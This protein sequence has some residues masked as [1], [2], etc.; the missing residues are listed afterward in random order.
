ME[1]IICIKT[2]YWHVN[3]VDVVATYLKTCF[4][5]WAQLK[6]VP[7]FIWRSQRAASLGT[8]PVSKGDTKDQDSSYTSNRP[9]L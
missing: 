2:E 1:N 6:M 7:A 9:V 8:W 4:I 5:Q 3:V